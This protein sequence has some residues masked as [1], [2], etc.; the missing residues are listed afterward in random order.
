MPQATFAVVSDLHCRL[1]TAANDSFLTV[2]APRLPSDRHP[3]ESLLEL[4]DREHLTADAL[5]VPGD[6]T[7]QASRE[8]L[9]QGLEFVLEIGR[10]LQ[11]PV[12]PVIG[13]HDIDSHRLDPSS[14][15]LEM[16][17]TLRKGFPFS[18]EGATHSFFS[19]GYCLQQV[20]DAQ[21]VAINTVI[22]HS[23]AASAKRGIFGIS[24]IEEMERALK[25]RIT[26]PIR[27]ALMHHHPMLHSSPFLKDTDVIE[28]GDALL[29]A[30]RRLGCRFVIHGHKHVTKLSY[31]DGI[32]V[33]AC[34]S[35][36]A[37]LGK[38]G[39]SIGNTF[40]SIAVTG[41]APDQ[42]R[43]IVRTWVFQYA[44]GWS[45]SNLRYKGFPY[46]SGFGRTASIGDIVGALQTLAESRD[47]DRFSQDQVLAAA[48][49]AEY[50]T[51][52]EREDVNLAL[53]ANGLKLD[54]Y[55]NGHLELWRSYT[56]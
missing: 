2:G 1:E 54:D 8:G 6:L 31:I 34:G 46:L 36:S 3:V 32:A 9:Q 37:M 27:G 25:N 19:E 33:L 45:R 30:L 20:A 41:N 12:I 26:S 24:R 17:R 10:K 49:D 50:L 52:S 39:T 14:P 16:V 55:D 51:P 47:G 38:V 42:V 53:S 40:H 56:P 28:A 29:G 22:D 48:P 43:G 23:D 21:L 5:L 15:P 4:I 35:F 18:D 7:N 11:V 13:N 44:A